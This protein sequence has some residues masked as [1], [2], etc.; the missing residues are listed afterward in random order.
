MTDTAAMRPSSRWPVAAMLLVVAAAWV[1]LYLQRRGAHQPNVDD[2][3]Y[4]LQS[5]TLAHAGSF[6]DLVH[7]VLH[8]GQTAARSPT[9]AGE[10]FRP[11]TFTEH[12]TRSQSMT[13]HSRLSGS[14]RTTAWAK[15]LLAADL[16]VPYT[17]GVRTA[18]EGR[19]VP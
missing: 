8:S 2:Y 13:T 17:G 1:P 5:L 11:P 18:Q 14:R 12:S 7:D 4:T 6:G 9:Q 19:R 15:A 10:H 3:L 16:R